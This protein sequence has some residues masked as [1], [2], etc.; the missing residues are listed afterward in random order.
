MSLI[1]IGNTYLVALFCM[2]FS[3]SLLAEQAIQPDPIYQETK[4][5]NSRPMVD[6]EVFDAQEQDPNLASIFAEADRLAERKVGNVPRNIDFVHAFWGQ[7]KKILKGNY[8]IKWHSP[9]ELNPQINYGAYG[10]PLITELEERAILNYLMA[11][12]DLSDHEIISIKRN[13]EGEVSIRTKTKNGNNHYSYIVEGAD[14]SWRFLKLNE[15][16]L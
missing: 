2:I 3:S 6:G 5:R 13:F 8:G 15:I 12:F 11:I 9:A 7:K 10:Q 14:N 1:K 4:I 16:A